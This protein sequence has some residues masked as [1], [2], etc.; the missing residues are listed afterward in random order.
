MSS[1][2]IVSVTIG[3]PSKSACTELGPSRWIETPQRPASMPSWSKRCISL[4]SPGVAGRDLA[5]S[6]PITYVIKEAVGMYCTTLTP[7]GVR[8]R[9]SRYSGIVSQSH[10]IPWRIDS[11]GI[12]SVRVMVSIDRSRKSGLHGAKP[13]PQL[14]RTT[15]VTPCHP[16]MVHQGSHR[17]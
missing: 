7:L 5:A 11:Y 13:K 4:R 8:S 10:V 9:E 15:D 1:S 3:E 14:P 12:A 2:A 16:E 17:I 6:R